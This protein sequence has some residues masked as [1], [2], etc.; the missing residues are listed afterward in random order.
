MFQAWNVGVQTEEALGI[1]AIGVGIILAIVVG[2][3]IIGGIKRI[4]H[5]AGILVPFMCVLYL[6]AGGVVLLMNIDTIPSILGL[7]VQSAFSPTDAGGAFIGGASFIGG[8]FVGGSSAIG[9]RVA[10][11]RSHCGFMS[12]KS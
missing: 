6:L 7:I 9:A 3:V 12:V 11:G 8:A 5:V 1:P 4:G 10:T 2:A